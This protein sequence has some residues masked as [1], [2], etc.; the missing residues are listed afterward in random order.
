MAIWVDF[1]EPKGGLDEGFVYT[2]RAD[3][4]LPAGWPGTACLTNQERSRRLPGCTGAESFWKNSQEKQ[5][6]FPP[7]HFKH[8]I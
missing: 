3:R 5:H 2:V 1:N 4:M 7:G 8:L 6:F